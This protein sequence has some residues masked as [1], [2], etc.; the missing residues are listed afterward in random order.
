MGYREN[1]L[2]AAYSIISRLMQTVMI[3]ESHRP[4]RR[5]IHAP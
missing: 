5:Q 3:A 2:S 4:H 1:Y